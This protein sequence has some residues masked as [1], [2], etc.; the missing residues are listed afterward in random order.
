[1]DI[2]KYIKTINFENKNYD[3][4]QNR[5]NID[6]YYLFVLDHDK[7]YKNLF[8][9]NIK[10][11]LSSYTN[12]TITIYFSKVF[13]ILNQI[14]KNKNL[15][16]IHN[17]YINLTKE[18][19]LKLEK[20]VLD[21]NLTY[22]TV[23]NYFDKMDNNNL[24]DN[25]LKVLLG[26][27]L[28]TAPVR[29]E[30]LNLK[31]IFNNSDNDKLND[32]ILIDNDKVYFILNKIKKK[33]VSITYEVESKVLTELII[34]SIK[35]YPRANL[36]CS[37][38]DKNKDVSKKQKNRYF[39]MIHPD[40]GINLLRSLYYTKFAKELIKIKNDSEKSRTSLNML[41]KYYIKE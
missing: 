5:I 13:N 29:T 20:P 25:I 14:V 41:L 36:I 7:L 21:T 11:K 37:I 9:E 27:Y 32:F 38:K 19:Y 10:K 39:K 8:D 16:A 1:M 28:L 24:Q 3:C 2:L 30:I 40:L 23:L 18:N 33:H 15:K 26:C 22:D 17:Y 6:N 4:I 35:R 34:D 31:I 12:H